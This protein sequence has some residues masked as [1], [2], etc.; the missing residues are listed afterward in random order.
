MTER[1]ALRIN[2]LGPFEVWRDQTDL[3]ASRWPR[4]PGSLLRLLA[5][6]PGRK[7]LREEVVDLFWP[8]VPAETGASNLR[9]T[10]QLLRRALGELQPSPIL[11]ERGW[12]SLNPDFTWLI[13]AERLAD[14]VSRSC[15]TALEERLCVEAASLYR[16]DVL[17]EDRYEDWAV[18]VRAAILRQWREL[19]L[20]AS[21]AEEQRGR[22]EEA[23]AWVRRQL[24]VDPLDEEFVERH[25]R[26]L[27]RLGRGTEA[28]RSFETFRELLRVELDV[29]PDPAVLAYVDELRSNRGAA[30]VRGSD[31]DEGSTSRLLVDVVPKYPLPKA[32]RLNG[33]E[34]VLEDVLNASDDGETRLVLVVGEAGMGKTTLLGGLATRLGEKPNPPLVLAGGSYAQEGRLPYGAFRD[35]LADYVSTQSERTL[36]AQTCDISQ[37]LARIL[38][39]MR[40]RIG[41]SAPSRASEA[42]GDHRLQLFWSIG[43]FLE[44]IAADRPLV[45]LLDDLQ[46]A[47]VSTIQ[48][49]HFLARQTSESLERSGLTIVGACRPDSDVLDLA[50][51][52]APEGRVR[53]VELEP[54]T[55]REVHEVATELL[56][57]SPSPALSSELLERSAGNPLFLSE[58][59]TLLQGEGA[60]EPGRHGLELATATIGALPSAIREAI[61][62]RFEHLDQET[63]DVLRLAG[64]LGREF[65]FPALEAAWSGRAERLIEVME[66][67]VRAEVLKETERGFFFRHPLLAQALYESTSPARRC[68]LHRRAAESLECL[69]GLQADDHPSELALHFESAGAGFEHRALHYLRLAGDRCTEAFAWTEAADY[70]SRALHVAES[71]GAL[72]EWIGELHMKAGD[73]MAST[74]RY[75]EARRHYEL[76]STNRTAPTPRAELLARQGVTWER[77]GAYEQALQA[78]DRAAE[79]AEAAAGSENFHADLRLDRA[80][81]LVR[82]GRGEEAKQLAGE[83]LAA[84]SG[85]ASVRAGRAYHLLAA[86]ALLRGDLDSAESTHARSLAVREM[87]GDERGVAQSWNQLAHVA[88]LRGDLAAVEE[89]HRQA[90][91]VLER[92]GDPEGMASSLSLMGLAASHR[93][94]YLEAEESLQ[95]SLALRE[96]IGDPVRVADCWND[97]GL[98][99]ARRGDLAEAGERLRRGLELT[100]SNASQS[101]AG[102]YAGLGLVAFGQ[103]RYDDAEGW[104]RKSLDLQEQI[105]DEYGITLGLVG[106]GLVSQYRGDLDRAEGL[107]RESLERHSRLGGRMWTL[108]AT[109]ALGD[110]YAEQGRLGEALSLL[111]RAR[112]SAHRLGLEDLEALAALAQARMYISKGRTRAPAAVVERAKRL[113]LENQATKTS[114]EALLTLSAFHL[115]EGKVSEARSAAGDAVDHASSSGLPREM[116]LGYRLLG[117]A[118]LAGGDCVAAEASFRR[119]VQ[120]FAEIGAQLELTRSKRILASAVEAKDAGNGNRRGW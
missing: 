42:D 43:R 78:F 69:Y 65:S 9:S 119:S 54:L 36:T 100:G 59:T 67:A 66:A 76:A 51:A 96:R 63:R 2:L 16:G 62:R 53:L 95:R 32:P 99:A 48:L 86:A 68:L 85:Q 12:V 30:G 105:G 3:E 91:G 64:V 101:L 90:L 31:Q 70:Y 107:Y 73:V 14:I 120:I 26:L 72:P 102:A 38:P 6:S 27:S 21:G 35:A 60:L 87:V 15:D 92:I 82:M 5:V 22:D 61:L 55:L 18:P 46:W 80:E 25:L 8:D 44:R 71:F 103:G 106:L 1:P 108:Y 20:Q 115:G 98:V 75:E 110:L 104:Y 50:R 47:D 93:G 37:D 33:R 113:A 19:C 97:L 39:E 114:V 49:L 41:A 10:I 89:R 4:R 118:D 34:L 83:A 7:R 111:R 77:Q 23:A 17:G 94:H 84:A 24:D 116:G 109:Y 28:L 112:R 52:G 117:Q 56:S 45:L 29:D 81:V 40:E 57:I 74:A 13:D 11:S 79:A 88:L 58:L